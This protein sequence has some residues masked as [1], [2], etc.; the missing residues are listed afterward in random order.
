VFRVLFPLLAILLGWATASGLRRTPPEHAVPGRPIQ[1]AEDGY[2]SSQS[3]RACHPDQYASWRGSYHRTMTQIAGPDTVRAD[4]GNV[5]VDDVHGRPMTL[6]VRDGRYLATFDDPDWDGRGGAPPRIDREVVMITGSHHQQIY[7]YA[8]GQHRL[9]GQL[10]GAYLIAEGRWIPRRMAVLHPPGDPV[11]SETGHWNSVCIACHTTHGKPRS[12]TPLGAEPVTAQVVDSTTVEHGIAC[13][14]CH[15]PGE[16]HVEA[17]RNPLR[18]YSL[19]LTGR[20]D[21]TTVLPTRLD[22]AKSSQV[23]GQCHGI[24]EFY[25]GAAERRANTAG[26]PFR[27]GDELAAT[28][29]VAQPSKNGESPT[30]QALLAADTGF[31]RDSFWPD[32][33]V[34][35]SGREYNGLL[36]SP[37]FARAADPARTLSCMSCHTL[38]QKPGDLRPRSEWA[39]DQLGEGMD[40]DAA[41]TQCHAPIAANL[42]RHTNHAPESSGSRCYNCHMPYTTYGLLKTIRSHTVGSPSVAET[43]NA[44]RPNACNLCH[45]DKTLRWTSDAL[46]R[47]Y[48]Q[49]AAALSADQERISAM[50]LAALEG[51]AG[52][53]VIAVEA[54]RWPPAQ[55]ASGT[56]WMAPFVAQLLD[57]SYDA[58]RFGA[59]RTLKS[60]PGFERIAYDFVAGPRTRRQVQLQVMRRWDEVRGA[61]AAGPGGAVLLA[62]DGGLMVDEMRRLIA[63]RNHRRILLRE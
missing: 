3:C 14:S 41:C 33:T 20:A 9:L 21:P 49:T 63:R 10:P 32:G 61:S 37:C 35:V 53:R 59:G 4:F 47:W 13:E 12:S 43:V 50:A 24:W 15:G 40:G 2:A 36:E 46:T 19:H 54:F 30:M 8:T 27:P 1:V 26:L 38:H 51:D 60:L 57:D 56:A 42:T 44:G 5:T 17:N 34:R 31:V 45:L 25:D 62:P 29:F 6:A 16:A 18:R 7:W 23:C 39:N 11:F 52:Q 55:Q 28:R 58:V 48:G 22:P